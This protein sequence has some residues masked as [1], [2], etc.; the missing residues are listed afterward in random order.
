MHT[1]AQTTAALETRS[2]KIHTTQLCATAP[3]THWVPVHGTASS[4]Q[5]YEGSLLCPA[6]AHTP[7]WVHSAQ[8]H[9]SLSYAIHPDQ[10]SGQTATTWCLFLLLLP[11]L[12]EP[13]TKHPHPTAH[14]DG[15]EAVEVAGA[16]SL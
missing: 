7:P 8:S 12:T 14:T 6:Y 2:V 15:A 10:T 13:T 4:T 5:P 1:H 9:Q 11:P 16:H 3:T